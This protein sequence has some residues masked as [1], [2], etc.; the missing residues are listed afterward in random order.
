MNP[1]YRS[2]KSFHKDTIAYFQYNFID[3]QDKYIGKSVKEVLNDIETPIIHTVP[4]PTDKKNKANGI[5]LS[6]YNKVT[7]Y[8]K[9]QNGEKFCELIVIFDQDV[10]YDP[11]IKIDKE[12]GDGMPQALKDYIGNQ[13]VKELELYKSQMPYK[14]KAK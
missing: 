14:P 7:N 5:R 4:E 8:V 12:N 11:F 1:N 3:N 13:T 2:L 10:A 6:Y 9:S